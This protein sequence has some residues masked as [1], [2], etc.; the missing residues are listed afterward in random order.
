MARS[1]SVAG[2]LNLRGWDLGAEAALRHGMPAGKA[3]VRSRA[4]EMGKWALQ[5]RLVPSR[6]SGKRNGEYALAAGFSLKS[7]R[8]VS[9]V[10]RSGFGSSVPAW[11][12]SMTA[13]ASLLPL[14]GVDPRRFQLRAYLTGSWQFASAWKGEIRVTERYRNYE[15]S[16]LSVRGDM[17][18]ARG[19]WLSVLRVEGVRCRDW[20]LLSYMEGGYKGETFQAYLRFSAFSIAQWEDRIYVYERD[21]PGNFSVPAYSGKGLSLQ[22]MAACKLR[23]G[24]W[25]LKAW[26]RAGYMLRVQKEPSPTLALQLQVQR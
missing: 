1:A 10:D 8:W 9:L 3:S 25:K 4:G 17:Q 23:M 21:A 15:P 19:P 26:L 16:R 14:P 12:L 5:L 7:G 2:R 20:G 24:K 6:F 22:G 11:K 18:F 13:D